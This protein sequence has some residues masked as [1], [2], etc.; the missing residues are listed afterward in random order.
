MHIPWVLEMFEA[1]TLPLHGGVTGNAIQD[2]IEPILG[3]ASHFGNSACGVLS[4]VVDK[5]RQLGG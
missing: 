1:A 2:A 5:P 3:F 4:I